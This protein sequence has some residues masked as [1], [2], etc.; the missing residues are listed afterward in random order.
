MALA[1]VVLAQL[2]TFYPKDQLIQ[3]LTWIVLHSNDGTMLQEVP[4]LGVEGRAGDTEVV[5]D[6][7]YFYALKFIA[8]LTGRKAPTSKAQAIP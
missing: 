7:S 1:S 3:I 8:R 6:R 2:Q 4:E 5:R